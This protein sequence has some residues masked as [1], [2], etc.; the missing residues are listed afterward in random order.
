VS[1]TTQSLLVVNSSFPELDQ[2]A[3]GLAEAGLLS[4]YVRPYSNL[5]RKWEQIISILPM[6]GEIYRRSIGR[7]TL[8]DGLTTRLIWEAAI[9][10]DIALAVA[11]RIPLP[12]HLGGRLRSTLMDARTR[13]LALAGVRALQEETAVVASWGCAQPVF[14]KMKQRGGLCLLNYSLAHHHFTRSLLQEEAAL[15]PDFADTFKG[16]DRPKWLE[17]RFDDEINLADRILVGSSFVRDSFQAEGVPRDKIEIIPYGTD[18]G[19]FQPDA[20]NKIK[21]DLTFNL[22]F[23][24]QIGQRKGIAYLLKAYE[25]FR[26]HGTHLRIVGKIQGN[27]TALRPYRNLFEHIDHMPRSY[28]P[29]IYREADVF[30]FPTLVEGMPLVVLEAMA[31]G[32]PVIVTP[33]GP[34]DIVRDGVD[35][36]VVPIRDVD[37]IVDR[38][39][40]LRRDP[41]LRKEMGKN[42]RQRALEFTW[43]AYRRTI[44][45][46]IRMWLTDLPNVVNQ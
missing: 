6:M 28:L 41:I 34:G 1:A 40:R 23:V 26:G 5:G 38:L 21:I 31:S 19:L 27:G 11:Q 18:T 36:F 35:G 8:P 25:R 46:K 39:E 3:A 10:Q 44:V 33:N 37:A 9:S 24:G 42:A 2:L 22:L 20:S 16:E 45:S 17:E 4:R 43:D 13:A 7:R 12:G 30:V 29:D 32:I 14:R 15:E